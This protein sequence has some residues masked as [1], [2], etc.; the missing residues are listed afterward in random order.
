MR[1]HF[2][3]L[4]DPT[5]T[6]ARCLEL[7]GGTGGQSGWSLWSLEGMGWGRGAGST[8]GGEAA[9]D[10]RTPAFLELTSQLIVWLLQI[11]GQWCCGCFE[12]GGQGDLS[13]LLNS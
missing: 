1:R 8:L 5:Q 3:P 11:K 13:I 7:G 10:L 2:S 6:G 4:Q 9:S 12:E